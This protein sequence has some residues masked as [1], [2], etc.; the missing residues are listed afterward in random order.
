M[1]FDYKSWEDALSLTIKK[2]ETQRKEVRMQKVFYPTK[3]DYKELEDIIL[4]FKKED[5]SND[6]VKT[7]SGTFTDSLH[8]ID[9]PIECFV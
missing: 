9:Y 6:L 2:L 1:S 8:V 3:E 4:G 5:M 7:T